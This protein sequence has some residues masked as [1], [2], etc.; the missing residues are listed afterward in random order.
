MAIHYK[1]DVL[2]ALKNAGFNTSRIR[3]EKL[4]AESTLQK[5]RC[6]EMVAMSNIDI[7]CKLL[8]CQPGDILVYMQEADDEQ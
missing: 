7:I 3:K 6:G 4:L 8:R 2:Q 5:L 1:F